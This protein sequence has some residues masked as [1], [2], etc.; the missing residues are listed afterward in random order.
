MTDT[1]NSPDILVVED[2]ASLRKLLIEELQDAG[3]QTA[4]A[5][6]A[7]QAW[8]WLRDKP[9]DLVISDLRLPGADAMAL[10]QQTRQLPVAP[11]FIII[12]GFG[13]V[14]Q[15]VD[16]LKE[17]ADDFLTKPV[18]L[19][20]LLMSVQRVNETRRLRLE[21]TRYRELLGSGDFHGLIGRSAPM[22]RLYTQITQIARAAGP[23]LIEGESGVG[24]ELVARALHA[25]SESADGPFIAVN[26]A[27]IPAELLE[28]EL[29]GHAAG[30]FSGAQ[31]ARRGL[32]LEASGGSLLLDE[33]GELPIGMQA[34]LLRVLQEQR[35]RPVGADREEHVEVR[36]LAATNSDLEREVSEGNFREDLFYRLN[37]FALQVPP[38]RERGED[39]EL[40]TARFIDEFGARLDHPIQGITDRA[41]QQ[42]KAYPFP[43]NVRELSNIIEWAVTFCHASQIDIEHL[44]DRLLKSA[45]IKID[46][47]LPDLLASNETELL[48]LQE[49]ERR[50]I[51]HVIEQVDGNKRRAA[52]ILGI[53]RRTLYRRLGENDES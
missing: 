34:K 46:A 8:Q 19:Q 3:Y 23:V 40:L 51:E 29:F 36:I 17:G 11:G 6:D 25:E 41:L 31:K 45:E 16:A 44:P 5:P 37:T 12:T 18:D 1:T 39:L 14:S 47:Q 42:L 53:G 7:E 32:F 24:K 30:A 48:P 9:V 49:L 27:A 20:H 13:T 4:G 15:A 26:C 22:Q 43:G 52:E 33:I 38:L 28:S 50:Y 21:L 35:L 10:L 2:D